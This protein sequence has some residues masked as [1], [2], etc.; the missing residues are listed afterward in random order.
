MTLV[1]FVLHLS[2]FYIES[3]EIDCTSGKKKYIYMS[4][5]VYVCAYVHVCVWCVY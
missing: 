1:S 5:R 3:G 2:L 4:V